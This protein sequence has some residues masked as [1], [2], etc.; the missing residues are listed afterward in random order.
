ML[1]LVYDV[2]QALPF[3]LRA[4][5]ISVACRNDAYM[6]IAPPFVFGLVS[7]RNTMVT[8]CAH[9]LARQLCVHHSSSLTVCRYELTPFQACEFGLA[10]F[11]C[12]R[13]ISVLCQRH[14]DI[15]L[16]IDCHLL[17]CTRHHIE[18][19]L[20]DPLLSR[21]GPLLSS[22]FVCVQKQL[23]LSSIFEAFIISGQS[24]KE[25]RISC[26]SL[27]HVL[28]KLLWSCIFPSNS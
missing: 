16:Q 1:F 19:E 20:Y 24:S 22:I 4:T 12:L 5:I 27:N 18:N 10:F 28:G 11:V 25:E 15:L 21:A 7:L 8:V 23:L 26:I 6:M 9:E 3:S 14:I 2:W 13:N 17:T